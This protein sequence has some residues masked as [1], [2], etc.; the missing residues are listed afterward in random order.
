M[1]IGNRTKQILD[2]YLNGNKYEWVLFIKMA[3]G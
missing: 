2:N 1:S 3:E